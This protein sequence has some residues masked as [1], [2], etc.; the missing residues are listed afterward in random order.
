MWERYCRGVS[1]IVYVV[2][3]ADEES[4]AESVTE[5]GELLRRTQAAATP[6][7]LLGNKNDLPG[8]LE[9][10]GLIDKFGLEG[11]QGREV[12]CYSISAREGHN[13]DETLKWL[14]K[15]AK[16]TPA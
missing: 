3:S 8:H 11:I 15:Y 7:L 1:A 2:D 5:F 12:G 9:L 14:M 10:Q 13:V 6:V 4:I 16:A